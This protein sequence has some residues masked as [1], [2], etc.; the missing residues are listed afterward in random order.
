MVLARLGGSTHSNQMDQR[1]VV[2]QILVRATTISAARYNMSTCPVAGAQRRAMAWLADMPLP[3]VYWMQSLSN[4]AVL[5]ADCAHALQASSNSALSILAPPD[6]T[7][8]PPGYYML[9][10]VSAAGVPS[11]A[12]FVLVTGAAPPTDS[13]VSGQSLAQ[14]G[15]LYSANNQFFMVRTGQHGLPCGK[16]LMHATFSPPVASAGHAERRQPRHLLRLEVPPGELRSRCK[17]HWTSAWCPSLARTTMF[18]LQVGG[19]AASAV[20]ASG[21]SG[22]GTGPYIFIMQSVCRT[23][24]SLT[25]LGACMTICCLHDPALQCSSPAQQFVSLVKQLDM[26][27][28]VPFRTATLYF[29]TQEAPQY[30]T[31]RPTAMPA[32]AGC[33]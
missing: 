4:K 19:S 18:P 14:L 33:S 31:P 12:T 29:M 1:H 22:S 2:L 6:S 10:L 28:R 27:S 16:I 23:R 9:F 20:W 7:V 8:A 17:P 30:S 5:T 25:A 11:V 24:L 15:T 32:R 26:V 3:G 13:L 21:T